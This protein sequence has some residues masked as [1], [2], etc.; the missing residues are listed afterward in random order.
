MAPRKGTD[1]RSPL[2]DLPP[3]PVQPGEAAT[4]QGG[5]Y[6]SVLKK[7]DDTAGAVIGKM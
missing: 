1:N 2:T 3:K 6:S 5:L 7:R 4:V